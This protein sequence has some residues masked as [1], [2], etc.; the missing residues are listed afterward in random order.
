MKKET[1]TFISQMKKH[2]KEPKSKKKWQSLMSVLIV[3]LFICAS[4]LVNN[5]DLSL[6]EVVFGYGGGSSTSTVSES[7]STVEVSP[8]SVAADGTTTSTITVTVKSTNGSTLSGKTV[9]VSSSRGTTT[10][11]ITTITGTTSSN[12]KATFSVK[13]STAGEAVISATVGGVLITDTATVTFTSVSEEEAT[14]PTTISEGDLIRASNDYKVYIVKGIYKRWIQTAS[15]FDC[16]GHLS[17][18]AVQEV[19]PATRDSYTNAWLVRADGY[20]EVYEIN[21]DM[22]KHWLNMT[23]EQF[24]AS[25][26]SWDMVYIINLCELNLYT[27]GDN[28]L[29]Q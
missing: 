16:Y 19:S 28:I 26:R 12:G 5:A 23:A 9:A 18:D 4:I 1:K 24:V 14:V 22:S 6:K 3:A 20:P 11:T 8:A 17:F 21:G 7:L 29:Y 2:F 13:S 10:D 15:I 25:G 27:T